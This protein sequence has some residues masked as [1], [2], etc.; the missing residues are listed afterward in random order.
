MRAFIATF[1]SFRTIMRVQEYDDQPK[2]STG[3]TMTTRNQ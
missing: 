3:L 1:K 2:V